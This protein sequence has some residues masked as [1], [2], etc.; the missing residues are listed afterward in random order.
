MGEF[1]ILAIGDIHLQEKNISL[2][3]PV[4]DQIEEKIRKYRITHV[5]LLGDTLHTNERISLQPLYEASSFILRL[6]SF[7]KVIVLIGNHDM[8][9]N[10]QFQSPI[11]PFSSL[12]R[13][14]NVIIVW[15]ATQIDEKILAVPYVPKGRFS[16]AILPFSSLLEEKKIEIVFAH[17]EFLGSKMSIHT[18]FDGDPWPY[19]VQIVS[20]HIHDQQVMKNI[21]YPGSL[22]YGNCCLIEK[23]DGRLK[24]KKVKVSPTHHINIH[25]SSIEELIS[26]LE[27]TTKKEGKIFVLSCL[28]VRETE[29]SS[30]LNR[31]RKDYP[32]V[33]IKCKK[34][35]EKKRENEREK[36]RENEEKEENFDQI[37]LSLLPEE[38]QQ[39]YFLSIQ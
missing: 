34:K 9:N 15:K 10:H 26:S 18:S 30:V 16:E 37:V 21:Y 36:K 20:G 7:C 22:E 5:V 23:E 1:R 31:I 32:N 24:L 8:I 35:R 29:K 39:Y 12:E 4:F 27:K 38:L 13:T 33:E 25:C 2:L 19:S 6:S 3:L 11:H 17:Q 14:E 28:N